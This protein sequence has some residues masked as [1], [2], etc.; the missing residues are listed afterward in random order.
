MNEIEKNELLE[1]LKSRAD[2]MIQEFSNYRSGVKYS[3]FVNELV[4]ETEELL[5]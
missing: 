2:F 4:H 5:K 1:I 3:K